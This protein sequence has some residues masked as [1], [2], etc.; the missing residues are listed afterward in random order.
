MPIEK[1]ADSPK[2]GADLQDSPGGRV[3]GV[4]TLNISARAKALVLEAL[5]ANRLSYGPFIRKLEREFAAQHDCRYGIMSNSGTSA[6]QI[7]LQAMKEL[8]GWQDGDE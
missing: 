3:I 5:N 6:L 4:G 2:A 7:A 1:N 8:H